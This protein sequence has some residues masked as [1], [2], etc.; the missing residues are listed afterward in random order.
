MTPPNEAPYA[1]PLSCEG[2]QLV[3]LQSEAY[4]RCGS[5][6]LTLRPDATGRVVEVARRQVEG[7]NPRFVLREGQV[8]VE[9]ER[10]TEQ[11][12]NAA[13]RDGPVLVP[14]SAAPDGTEEVLRP[15]TLE[16]PGPT[17][18]PSAATSQEPRVG[19]PPTETVAQP[20][21]MGF[22][23]RNG[24]YY[25]GGREVRSVSP[26]GRVLSSLRGE[27]TLELVAPLREYE[28]VE[29]VTERRTRVGGEAGSEQL[30][31]AVVRTG[32][33][34]SN[35]AVFRL[36]LDE[37]VPVGAQAFTTNAVPT[38]SMVG[39]PRLGGLWRAYLQPRLFFTTQQAGA[40]VLLDA[41]VTYHF[42]LPAYVDVGFSPA[43]FAGISRSS[44]LGTSSTLP[45]GFALLR[46]TA[47]LDERYIALGGGLGVGTYN[48]GSASSTRSAAFAFVAQ[49]RFGALDGIHL[50]S[51]AVLGYAASQLRFLAFTATFQ[52]PMVWSWLLLRAGG[53]DLGFAYGE[54]ALRVRTYGNGDRGSLFFEPAVGASVGLGGSNASTGSVVQGGPHFSLGVEYRH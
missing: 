8:V 38:H 33:Q 42:V 5:T 54:L 10:T 44:A 7:R 52:I 31:H 21:R 41:L 36:G 13:H 4:V 32:P 48:G 9:A 11:R 17:R 14:W 12:L 18:A 24:T 25:L 37:R 30:R 26:I 1:T 50:R 19:E 2:E 40:G 15:P 29:F 23:E 22:R 39:P 16:I 47:G 3:V 43:G 49:A 45:A 6:V 51:E 35:R 20:L 34:S 28:N 27:V 46:A 53:G